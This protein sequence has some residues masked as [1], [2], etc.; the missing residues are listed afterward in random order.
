MILIQTCPVRSFALAKLEGSTPE[1]LYEERGQSVA[2]TSYSEHRALLLIHDLRQWSSSTNVPFVRSSRLDGRQA[3]RPDPKVDDRPS[4]QIRSYDHVAPS[5]YAELFY[6]IMTKYPPISERINHNP[7]PSTAVLHRAILVDMSTSPGLLPQ[8]EL[9]P[10]PNICLVTEAPSSD[11]VEYPQFIL[12]GDS[13]TQFST[14]TLQAYLQTQYIR[15]LDVINRGLSGFTLP[16][17]FGALQKFL[18]LSMPRSS[19]P[20]IKIV[21]VWFGANDSCVPGESQHVDLQLYVDTMKKVIEYPLLNQEDPN[22]TRIIIITP[23]PVNEHQFERSPSGGFQRRAGITSQYARAAREAAKAHGVFFLD[24]WTALM[25]KVGW[26]ESMG[27][28]CCCDHI[29]RHTDITSRSASDVQHIPGC[30]HFPAHSPSGN[31]QLSDFLTDGLHLTKLGYDVLF[32]ELLKLIKLDIP[33]CAPESLPFVLPE[34]SNAL[35]MPE[36]C[37]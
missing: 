19:W 10:P 33:E 2:D 21:T 32:W 14:L 13:I 22:R 11:F 3:F 5:C 18:P 29:P 6:K 25:H 12:F 24:L 17:G 20:K 34:W 35:R 1:I 15:R 37:S 23:P 26:V 28:E 7:R 36:F 27:Y 9:E 4:A 8:N 31:Y 16:M 30:Y